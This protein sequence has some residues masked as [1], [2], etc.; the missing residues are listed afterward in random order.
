MQGFKTDVWLHQ[1]SLRELTTSILQLTIVTVFQHNKRPK[2]ESSNK[3]K[4]M[5]IIRIHFHLCM[6]KAS[7]KVTAICIFRLL[8]EILWEWSK[9]P[10][11]TLKA[12]FR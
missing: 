9:I 12:L 5:L 4:E 7:N 8:E 6:F 10:A 3:E 1:E 2:H 11:L